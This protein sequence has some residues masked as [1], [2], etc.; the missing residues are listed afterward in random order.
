MTVTSK[1]KSGKDSFRQLN[2]TPLLDFCAF[3]NGVSQNIILNSILDQMKADTEIFHKC[4]YNG[5]VEFKNFDVKDD[6]FFLF[7]VPGTHQT[8][9]AL[10][11]NQSSFFTLTFEAI[12]RSPIK[13]G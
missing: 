8:I 13:R 11:N 7:Y 2:Q 6:K 4:P 10:S 12:I 1:V 3:L 5:L 9:I